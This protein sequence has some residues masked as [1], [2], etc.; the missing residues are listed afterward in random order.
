[1]SAHCCAGTRTSAPIIGPRPGVADIVLLLSL[2]VV[3]L[4]GLR[5]LPR[6]A[7]AALVVGE[8][9]TL[10]VALA[11]MVAPFLLFAAM[12]GVLA[13]RARWRTA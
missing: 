1:V 13:A 10:G 12:A 8:I 3:V 5:S 7:V 2:I 9:Q 11:P 6:I 4:G